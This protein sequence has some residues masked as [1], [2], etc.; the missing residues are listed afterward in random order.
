MNETVVEGDTT[1]LQELDPAFA[2]EDLV[3][4]DYVR[5]AIEK[6]PEWADDP[7]VS[8]EHPFEREE[9]VSV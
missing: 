5:K 9:V 4:Y 6:F 8:P 7:S 3:N 2:A 1:F